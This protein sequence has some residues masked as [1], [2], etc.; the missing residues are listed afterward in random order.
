MINSFGFLIDG[1]KESSY[2]LI[3]LYLYNWV[4][5]YNIYINIKIFNNLWEIWIIL[6]L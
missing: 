4:I 3:S 5:I 6:Y 2:C 1:I